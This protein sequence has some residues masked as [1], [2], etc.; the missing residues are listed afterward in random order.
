MVPL[1]P[2]DELLS[3][4][5]DRFTT[6]YPKF[7]V[8]YSFVAVGYSAY[9]YDIL[10]LNFIFKPTGTSSQSVHMLQPHSDVLFEE[11]ALL[12]IDAYEDLIDKLRDEKC[13]QRERLISF[14]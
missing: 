4:E 14:T 8:D 9:L 7:S 13:Y 3:Q 2:I 10:F 1:S 6:A 11:I 5:I 12:M